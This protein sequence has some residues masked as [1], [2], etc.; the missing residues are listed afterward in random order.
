MLLPLVA[1]ST[2]VL[3]M[4]VVKLVCTVVQ[5]WLHNGRRERERIEVDARVIR[6]VWQ[7]LEVEKMGNFENRGTYL[8]NRRFECLVCSSFSFENR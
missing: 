2:V 8:G 6:T 4:V 7:K 5:W 3:V 1:I